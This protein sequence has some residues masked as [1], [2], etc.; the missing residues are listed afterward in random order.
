[1]TVVATMM[2]MMMMRA[3]GVMGRTVMRGP[4]TARGL[5]DR[6]ATRTLS[7]AG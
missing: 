6:T 7:P 3:L 1:V 4:A 5:L 2:M